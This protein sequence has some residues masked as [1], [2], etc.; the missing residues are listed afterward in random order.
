MNPGPFAVGSVP[1]LLA[2]LRSFL[3][4]GGEAAVRGVRGIRAS[5]RGEIR[6]SP[7]ARWVP[8]TAEETI[9]A[10]RSGFR[11]Q[12]R[13][14]ANPLTSV[15]VTDA[16]ENG[17]G[18][19]VVT[20]GPFT[21]VNLSGA[22]VDKG[23]LQRYLGY[24]GYCPP[25]LIQHSTLVCEDVGPSTLRLRDAADAAGASVEME[26]GDDGRPLVTRALRPMTVGK[27]SVLTPW[28][29]YGSDEKERAGFRSWTRMEARWH[30]PEG[31]FT[32]VRMEVTSLEVLRSAV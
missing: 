6:S 23:E 15:N 22:E 29:A 20:K 32:Y 2:R 7:V 19:L 21:L 13:M 26:M 18:R 31:E 14:G 3:I 10:T 17:H 1:P 11:W 27:R 9:E 25:M 4:P 16:Y 28:S 8:F 30:P 24:V 12:A 5:Q